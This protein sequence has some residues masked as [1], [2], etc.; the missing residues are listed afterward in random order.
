V[1][2]SGS[3][4]FDFHRNRVLWNQSSHAGDAQLNLVAWLGAQVFASDS[5]VAGSPI[6]GVAGGATDNAHTYLTNLTVADNTG[7]Y[8]I[9]AMSD[10]GTA[11]TIYNCIVYRNLFDLLLE[12]GS[13]ADFNLVGP[14]P[15]FVNAATWDY[16]LQAASPARDFGTPFP[17][18]GLGRFDMAGAPRWRGAAPDAGAYELL[19]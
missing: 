11:T 7:G 4:R 1:I 10:G 14:D 12:R 13:Y 15:L 2:A 5:V 6:A 3:S 17:P 9:H 18:G 16:R 19:P 8:G